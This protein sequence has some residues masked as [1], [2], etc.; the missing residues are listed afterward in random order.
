MFLFLWV[1]VSIKTDSHLCFHHLYLDY[2]VFYN[3]SL[4]RYKFLTPPPLLLAGSV[5]IYKLIIV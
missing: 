5:F 3:L 1:I 2:F 4:F